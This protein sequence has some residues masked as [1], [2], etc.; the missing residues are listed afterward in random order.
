MSNVKALI[1][2]LLLLVPI[3]VFIFISTFGE[4]HFSLRT[5]FPK[6]DD[7][8]EVVY[9]EKGDTVFN[10]VPDFKLTSQQ[11]E[12]ISQS[13]DLSD[14][15]YVADFFFARCTSICKK[16]SS[17]LSRVQEAY[18][19]NPSVKLVSITVNPEHDSVAVL[20]NY[21]AQYGADP[22]KWMLLT[23]PKDE[24]Y[25]LAQQGFYLPVQKVEGQDDFIHSEKF[26]LVD[27]EQRV[28]GIYDGTDP[29]DVDRLIIEINVLLDEYSKSK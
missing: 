27:K 25:S 10:R 21:A 29:K 24:I 28:R 12:T 1:L 18:K 8:G 4:H 19:N 6:V 2:G 5:Y 3:F 22:E 9:N 20:Q 15:I 11:G 23:G 26:M 14:V 16:M 7:A 13:E 17:Q